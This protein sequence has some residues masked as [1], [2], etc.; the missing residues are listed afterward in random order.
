MK[1]FMWIILI[2]GLIALVFLGTLAIILA[3]TT[4]QPKSL[5]VALLF[6]LLLVTMGYTV[7]ISSMNENRR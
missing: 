5:V 2:L 4:N 7:G 3:I 1:I 6:A